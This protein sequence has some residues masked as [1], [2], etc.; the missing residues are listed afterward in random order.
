MGFTTKL[1]LNTSRMKNDGTFPII[2]RITFNRKIV[3]IPTGHCVPQKDWDEKKQQVKSSSKVSNSITRLN[4]V[5]KSHESR[6]YDEV[7][8]L[9]LEDRLNGL[10]PK[11]LKQILLSTPSDNKVGV[12]EHIDL[13]IEEKLAARKNSSALAYRGV[14]RKLYALMGDKL[15]RYDQIDYSLLKKLETKHLADGGGMGGFGVYM[16]TLRAIYNRAI[17]DNLVSTERYPFNDY[18]IKSVDTQRRALSE[19]DFLKFKN[20]DLQSP[21]LQAQEYFMASFYMR[22][23]NYIDLAYLKTSNIEGDF[24]RVRY[25][26]NKTGK[27]FSIKISDPLKTILKKYVSSLAKEDYIFPI[28]SLQTPVEK[29]HETIKNKR[30]RL[31][32]KL[33]KIAAIHGFEPF[34]IYAARHTYA[35]MGKRKGVPTAVIQE[36]LGHKTEAITQAYLSSFDNSVVDE[37]DLLIMG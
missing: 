22:G 32:Q 30:K 12:Y 2:T 11:E 29:H 15:H 28:L 34:T 33:R 26:R 23:M 9:E 3:K 6:I 35:T 4:H 19:A 21:L 37:Y 1:L 27:Y 8:K 5:L 18:K 17:K 24:D 13:L 25:R 31:N 36:S 16:R 7:S 20:L 10:N 14:K